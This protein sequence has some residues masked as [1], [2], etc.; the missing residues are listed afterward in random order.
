VPCRC[1]ELDT[2]SKRV[3]RLQKYSNLGAL[4]SITFDGVRRQTEKLGPAE[5]DRWNH[6]LETSEAYAERP[7]GW[8]VIVG[9][10]GSGKT[11]L[12]AAIANTCL[13]N[14]VQ[15]FYITIPD[16]LDHL[17]SSYSP[18]SEMT[19]DELFEQVRNAPLLV[20][21]D[22]GAQSST[23]WAKEKLDQLLS[24]RYTN[25]L[26]TVIVSIVS[27]EQL[28]DRVRSRLAN[29]DFCH[30]LILGVKSSDAYL[31]EW[32]PG[33]ELQKG[34]TFENFDFKRANLPLEQ[35][36]NLETAYEL[37]INFAKSPDGWL[38]FAGVNGSGKTHLASAIVNYRYKT[39][40]TALFVVVPDFL[41]H[42]RSTFSPDSKVSY[43]QLFEGVKNAELLV[44]DDF[45]EQASTPWAQEKLY[46]VVNHRYNAR[47]ATVFTITCNLDEM[48][49][50]I[51]SR[52]G[53][54]KT[55]TLFNI[56]VP[57]YRVD[58]TSSRRSY[59]GIKK[60]P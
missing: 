28:E 60:G 9:P 7:Q 10:S 26:P 59:R 30:V 38:V 51:A 20:L 56:T 57:D 23:S 41:D 54:H 27:V 31:H 47:L 21:D 48:D 50:R 16:L 44:L 12:A 40:K 55:S 17:R 14:N 53:D 32:A 58:R 37:A 34:M 2:E 5:R 22:F 6:A 36:Q 3:E 46:Q 15:T 43:D 33:F 29:T 42:L 19:Y 13:K 4:A 52:L 8:F 1:A 39:G 11:R 24:H 49:A 35:R 25:H 18:S 45:G